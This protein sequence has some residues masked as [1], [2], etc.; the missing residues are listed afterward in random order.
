[1]D[2]RITDF[3]AKHKVAGHTEGVNSNT[4]TFLR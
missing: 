1:M 3:K 4:L 2:L